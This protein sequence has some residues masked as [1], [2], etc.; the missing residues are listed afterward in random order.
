MVIFV[1]TILAFC[2]NRITEPMFRDYVADGLITDVEVT[3]EEGMFL[4]TGKGLLNEFRLRV[5]R[6]GDRTFV[7]LQKLTSYLQRRLN[8]EK[9]HVTL[10]EDGSKQIPINL[11]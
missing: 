4:V 9:F 6:G 7:D 11:Q 3:Q 5:A 10:K 2:M 1:D 8:V